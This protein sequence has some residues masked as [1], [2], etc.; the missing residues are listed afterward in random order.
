VPEALRPNLPNCLEDL[1]IPRQ[2]VTDLLLRYL[3]L[4]GSATLTALHRALHL[5]IRVVETLFRDLRQQQLIEVKGM[6]GN[7]YSFT[8]S[9][10]GHKLAEARNQWCQ[11]A[12]P[13]PVS[14]AQYREVVASQA[15]HPAVDRESLRQAFHDLVLP[16]KLLDQ[17]GPAL[18]G[19]QTLFLYGETGSGK[20]SIA[21]RLVR[22]CGDTVLVP[23][24]IEVDG[25]IIAVFDPAVHHP[26]TYQDENLDPRWVE[27]RRPCI[28]VG[29]EL[30]AEMLELRLDEATRV[31]I[32]PAQMKANNGVLVIDDFGRQMLSPR[33]L[34]NRWITALDRRV[35]YLTLVSGMKFQVP[36]ELLVVFSTNLNP[37]DLA[38]EA[39]LRRI[40]AKILI[41]NTSDALFEEIFR[42]V[43]GEHS[44][45]I[46]PDAA[47]YL[48]ERCLRAGAKR[49]RACYPADLCRLLIAIGQ[50]EK[51]PVRFDRASIDRA[52]DLY[53]AKLPAP[54]GS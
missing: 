42:R 12:G 51:H 23:H 52:V 17:L 46:E 21:E 15:S 7:D 19:R 22:I 10:S 37:S 2:L 34:L 24:A 8:L 1:G 33:D 53:F 26:A 45:P 14:I 16:D 36:F 50:Y 31:F 32:A 44:I 48:R 38:D 40:Q 35:D 4:N 20:T 18:V 6:A 9:S 29:G 13:C 5:S 41:E 27:C 11:Y 3:W 43:A 28:T 54:S 47:R 39:F 25:H 30:S 49:L